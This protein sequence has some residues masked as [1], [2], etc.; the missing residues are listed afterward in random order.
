[1]VL[2]TVRGDVQDIGKN[3]VDIILT[4]NGYRVVNHLESPERGRRRSFVV[5]SLAR[6]ARHR[7]DLVEGPGDENRGVHYKGH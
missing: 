1:V 7:I 2:A 5:H 3:L 6:L 4:N